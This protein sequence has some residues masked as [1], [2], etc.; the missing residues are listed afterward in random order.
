M[1]SA[2]IIFNNLHPDIFC[3][4]DGNGENHHDTHESADDAKQF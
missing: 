3:V 4:D 2:P 1:P